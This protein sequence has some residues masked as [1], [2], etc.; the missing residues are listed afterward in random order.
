M[1]GEKHSGSAQTILVR[2]N[3]QNH[4]WILFLQYSVIKGRKCAFYTSEENVKCYKNLYEQK[5]YGHVK[6]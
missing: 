2:G 6:S 5:H 4:L 1:V 3:C